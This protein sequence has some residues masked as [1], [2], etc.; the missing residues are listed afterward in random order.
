MGIGG[1]VIITTGHSPDSISFISDSKEA[2]IG[3]L[4]PINQFVPDDNNCLKSWDLIK[5][6]GVKTV[7]PSHAE[8]FDYKKFR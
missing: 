3:D 2:V 8:I 6:K 5:Q 4:P 7:Y 1:E